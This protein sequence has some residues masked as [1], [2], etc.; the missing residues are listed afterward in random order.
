MCT[1]YTLLQ[2]SLRVW[3]IVLQQSDGIIVVSHFSGEG[4]NK[5][6]SCV[7]FCTGV[8]VQAITVFF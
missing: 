2:N 4:I 8:T 5:F 7:I 1:M 6:H 3:Q